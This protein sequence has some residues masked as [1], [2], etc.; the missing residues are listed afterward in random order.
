MLMSFY[1]IK[2]SL[3]GINSIPNGKPPPVMEG[4]I[5]KKPIL[6]GLHHHYYRDAS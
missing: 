2:L 5:K 6:F 4:K 1:P 3:R